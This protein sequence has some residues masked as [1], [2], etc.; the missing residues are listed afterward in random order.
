M[1]DPEGFMAS[2]EEVTADVE[3]AGEP[4]LAVEPGD[5]TELHPR[6]GT[7]GRGVASHG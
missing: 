4:E 2:V 6:A 7:N 5:A 3:M 1:V